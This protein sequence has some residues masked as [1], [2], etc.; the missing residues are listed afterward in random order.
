MGLLLV[1]LI[2]YS[3]VPALG[4][5]VNQAWVATYNAPSNDRDEAV[6]IAVGKK[7]YIYITGFSVGSG[8]DYCTIRYKPDGDT[9]WVRRYSLGLYNRDIATDLAVDDSGS[10]CVTGRSAGP[11]LYDYATIKYKPNGD[12]AWVRR[13]DGP[14]LAHSDDKAYAVATDD[15]SNVYVTGYSAIGG[16]GADYA[17]IKYKPTGDTGWVRRYNGLA[18]GNDAGNA[19]AVDANGNVCVTGYSMGIGTAEDYATIKYSPVGDSLWMRR[20]N[21]TAN[22]TDIA[23]ALAVD[24][25]GNVYVTGYS[26]G[27]E[28]GHDCVTIKYKSNGDTAWV[29]RY[30][31]P[32]NDND[33]AN[34]IAVDASGNVFVAGHSF[35]SVTGYD[36]LT[37]KY[38]PNG[39]TLWVRRY[40][41]PGNDYDEITG[42]VVGE[43]GSVYV[44][45]RST[46]I[47]TGFDFA[48][49]KYES[50]GDLQ[51]VRRYDGPFSYYDAPNDIALDDSG[52]VYVTGFSSDIQQNSDFITIKYSPCSFSGNLNKD[53]HVSI[54]DIVYLVN[55]LFKSWPIP[56]PTCLADVNGDSIVSLADAIYLANYVFKFGPAPVVSGACCL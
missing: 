52:N 36:Y 11:N 32:A 39:D 45:G 12:T 4:Q 16:T 14:D 10:V 34:A 48:T 53:T 35:A 47:G 26:V 18:N 54:I 51:W 3:A 2:L 42:L 23:T 17:T 55:I 1:A 40:N 7:G 6:G 41:G 15:R 27:S 31:G 25:V 8:W 24:G 29:R 20:Y 13:Y 22:S 56:G 43:D 5:E 50:N 37:I 28:P 44:T 19:V 49:V 9:V 30:D 46:G 21:G 38:G 33:V